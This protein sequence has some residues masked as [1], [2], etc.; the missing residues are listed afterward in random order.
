[1]TRP[2]DYAPRKRE[3]NITLCEEHWHRIERLCQDGETIEDLVTR[4]LDH[5]QQGVYRSGAWE[6]DWLAQIVVLDVI[7]AAYDD[8]VDPI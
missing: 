8:D 4:L 6:R 1:M 7:E 5:V 3:L 2:G